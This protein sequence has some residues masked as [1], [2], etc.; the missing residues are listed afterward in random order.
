MLQI[1]QAAALGRRRALPGGYAFAPDRKEEHVHPDLNQTL[2]SGIDHARPVVA[3][4]IRG[5]NTERPHSAP[6]TQGP[7]GLCRPTYRNRRSA[8]RI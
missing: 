1:I 5:Y 3:N 2:F 4:P 7:G 8:S 6:R